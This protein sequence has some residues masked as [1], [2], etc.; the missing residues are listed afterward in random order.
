MS[1][2]AAILMYLSWL[3]TVAIGYFASAY[4]IKKFDAKW[5]EA[6]EAE[7]INPN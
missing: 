2:F 6:T 3:V 7:E 5:K 1:Y 4:A